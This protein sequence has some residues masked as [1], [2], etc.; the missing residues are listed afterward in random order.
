MRYLAG[1]LLW[2]GV[3]L[4]VLLGT[5]RLVHADCPELHYTLHLGSKHMQDNDFTQQWN[6]ENLGLGIE[7]NRLTAGAYKNSIGNVSVY[8]GGVT[9]IN[10]HIGIKYGAVTGYDLPVAPYAAGYARVGDIE[11]TLIPKTKYNPWVIGYSLRW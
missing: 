11:L 10:N 9:A 2:V 5:I 4:A 6:E 1:F 3:L 7:C 8:A